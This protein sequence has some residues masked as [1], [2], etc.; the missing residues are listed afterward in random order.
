VSLIYETTNR[1]G[2]FRIGQDVT[3]HVE[4]ARAD[5]SVAVPESALV[6]EGDQL[7][8]FVQVSGETFEKREIR[9]GI[10]DTGFV[11]VLDG[12]RAGER[13]AT[14]GAYAIRL[15]SISGVIPAHGHAH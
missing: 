10:R 15:S 5:D 8:A 11:Q 7:V 9:A 1:E 12:I 6:E 14:K 13:V 3:L 4:T 2:R